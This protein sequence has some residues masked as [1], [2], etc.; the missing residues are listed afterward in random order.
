RS[1][2][3][4]KT[5]KPVG[6][7]LPEKSIKRLAIPRERPAT[8]YVGTGFGELYKSE[9][10]GATWKALD[11]GLTGTDKLF[12]L[13]LDPHDPLTLF[14]G[15]EDGLKKSTDGGSSWSSVG[16]GLG[17]WYCKGV[18]FHPKKKGTMFAGTTG[19][20]F[21]KSTDGGETFE[22]SSSGLGAGWT[23]RIYAPPSGTGPVFAQLSVG[24]YRQ[25]G[26]G[27]WTELPAP[28]APGKDAKVDGVVFD[29]QSPKRVFAHEGS[30]W[31]RSED[32]GKS[33]QQVQVPE[34]GLRDMM[35]G[36]M[37]GPHFNGLAQDAG[38]PKIF[39]AGG[40]WS[41]DFGEAAVYRSGHGGKNWDPA[42][43]GITGAVKVL[44]AAAAGV[45]FA[46][47]EKDGIFRTSD[48]GKSWSSVRSGEIRDFAIDPSK[49]DHLYV[50]AKEGLYR[51]SDNGASWVKAHG[52]KDDDV[53]AV[54]VAAGGK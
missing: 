21:F 15:T 8:I 30:K 9:D 52:I 16:G 2:D 14:A 47:T 45:G 17:T 4:G 46:V 6:E 31:W 44:R 39:Y 27:A 53:E 40:S 51:S 42:G 18:A 26:P 13:D 1:T 35:K 41:K 34:P 38:D 37:G 12:S 11:L 50:A 48:G 23:S 3:G 7:G 5:W 19:K 22:P 28:F 24:F 54:A 20:G 29:R 49:P 33:W 10:S 25:D 32:A 36:K 43:S